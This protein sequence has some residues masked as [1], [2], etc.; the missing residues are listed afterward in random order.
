MSL[1]VFVADGLVVLVFPLD[2]CESSRFISL[3]G[4]IINLIVH[5]HL[6]S[7]LVA[8]EDKHASVQVSVQHNC[9]SCEVWQ[10]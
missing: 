3:K 7:L 1:I 6:S 2:A 9:L 10:R 5:H 4:Y 8:R